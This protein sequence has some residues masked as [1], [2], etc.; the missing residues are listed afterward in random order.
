MFDIIPKERRERERDWGRER[1]DIE[2]FNTIPTSGAL[3]SG[4][5]INSGG[6]CK[7]SAESDEHDHHYRDR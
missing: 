3:S 5:C 7:G 6:K 1:M 2:V 4:L